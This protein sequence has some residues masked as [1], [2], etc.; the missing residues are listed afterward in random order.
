[1][2]CLFLLLTVGCGADAGRLTLTLPSQLAS[3]AQRIELSVFEDQTCARLSLP[4]DGS[5]EPAAADEFSRGALSE[6]TGQSAVLKLEPVPAEVPLTLT[7]EI[8]G[9]SGLLQ[10]EGCK[11]DVLVRTG[12]TSPVEL[13]LRPH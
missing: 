7:A 1:M 2:R 9:N 8:F 6:T 4:L 5:I 12:E 10:F 3:G 13:T 11:D